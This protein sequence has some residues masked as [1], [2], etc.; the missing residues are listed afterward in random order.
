[1]RS[2]N[3]TIR[4]VIRNFSSVPPELPVAV[5][6]AWAEVEMVTVHNHRVVNGKPGTPPLSTRRIRRQWVTPTWQR[7]ETPMEVTMYA[8]RR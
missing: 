3:I 1:M 8:G 6:P 4:L 2:V 7:L 5:T